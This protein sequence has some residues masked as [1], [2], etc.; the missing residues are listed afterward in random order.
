MK[1]VLLIYYHTPQRDSLKSNL[2]DELKTSL[3]LTEEKLA[4]EFWQYARLLSEETKMA[5]FSQ[6]EN[7]LRGGNEEEALY[8]VFFTTDR[9]CFLL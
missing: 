1:H 4:L 3:P 8:D 7:N 5:V 2:T 6:I 9:T